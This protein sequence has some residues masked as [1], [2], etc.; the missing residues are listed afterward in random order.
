VA[1]FALGDE[2]PPLTR[3]DVLKAQPEDLATAEPPQQHRFDHRPIPVGAQRRDQRVDLVGV[4][5]TGQGAWRSDQRHP[6]HGTLAGAAHRQTA[7]YRIAGHAGVA[8]DDQVLVEPGDRRQ[9]SFDRAGRQPGLTVLDPHHAA[10]MPRRALGLDECQ[11]IRGR[12]L[13]GLLVADR[14]EHLQ[15]ERSASTVFQRARAATNSMNASSSG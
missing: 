10:A 7:G 6:A 15:V 3:T 13:D 14:E 2:H 9:P 4:D 8:A 11:H 12:D 1:A 5:H